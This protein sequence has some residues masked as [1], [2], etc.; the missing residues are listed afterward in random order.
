M[1]NNG[2]KWQ[3][4][5]SECIYS[6]KH[7]FQCDVIVSDSGTVSHSSNSAFEKKIQC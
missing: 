4:I 1:F 3:S 5:F 7:T 6:I 2:L